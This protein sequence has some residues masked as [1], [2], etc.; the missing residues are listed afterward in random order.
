MSKIAPWKNKIVDREPIE[1]A[2]QFAE[3][4]KQPDGPNVGKNIEIAEFQRDIFEALGRDKNGDRVVNTILITVPRKNGKTAL[5][6][7]M[8]LLM[9]CTDEG[10]RFAQ[11]YSCAFDR[12][13][14]SV[15]YNYAKQIILQTPE[16]EEIIKVTDS[17]KMM[18]SVITGASFQALS[19]EAKSKH[20]RSGYFLVFDELHAFNTDSE[21]YDTMVTSQGAWGKEALK[22][23]IGTQSPNDNSLMSRLVD[24]GKMV[25]SGEVDDDKFAAF[26]WE[27]DEEN[28]DIYDEEVWKR[29]NPGI[30]AGFRS[31]DEMR[32]AGQKAKT[33]GGSFLSSFKNLYLNMRI[34]SSTPF[35]SKESWMSCNKP[36]DEDV[37]HDSRYQV[38][39]GLDLSSRGDLTCLALVVEDDELNIHVKI[40]AWTPA[41]LVEQHEQ[42][43]RAPYKQWI[44]D[45]YIEAVPG[46]SISYDWIAYRLA[47][48]SSEFDIVAINYDRWR[49]NEL[50]H[51]LDKIGAYLE[52]TP[53]GQGFKDM[54]PAIEALEHAVA[55]KEL[56]HGKNPVLTWAVSNAVLTL[57][58]AGNRKLDKSKAHGRIDPSV[59]LAMALKAVRV[60]REELGMLAPGR[61]AIEFV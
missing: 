43:D 7:I 38:Y 32:E 40:F 54:S 23:I 51:E 24:Y 36:P 11:S 12:D 56:R 34:D 22:V 2:I 45:E 25:N 16:L 59:A 33:L 57:D 28:D 4:L 17:K 42:T 9:I 61:N 19:A 8:L 50:N 49:I 44:L 3:H 48:I 21:L 53:C 60:D 10:K 30:D 52:L 5:I 6:A 14:A 35:I 20:G 26:I 41:E 27:A 29:C 15:I 55:E 1:R 18:S 47:E 39:G 31:L 58:P 13:Q 37:F 46:A